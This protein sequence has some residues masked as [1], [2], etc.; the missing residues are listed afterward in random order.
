MSLAAGFFLAGCD[1]LFCFKDLTVG[2][3]R[4]LL[5]AGSGSPGPFPVILTGSFVSRLG[6]GRKSSLEILPV[7]GMGRPADPNPNCRD[8][9]SSRTSSQP[10]EAAC[11]G[12][13]RAA[14]SPSQEFRARSS[15]GGPGSCGVAR[16]P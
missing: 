1:H 11:L 15:P 13:R 9:P 14:L 16:D 5:L 10:H 6:V 3:D 12:L 7:R 4:R 8:P 2:F